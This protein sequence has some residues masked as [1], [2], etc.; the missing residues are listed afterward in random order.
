MI[1]RWL[2]WL[3]HSW[4]TC[5]DTGIAIHQECRVCGKRRG[6]V[7]M[8]YG[9]VWHTSW[10]LDEIPGCINMNWVNGVTNSLATSH[11]LRIPPQGGSGTAPPQQ[12]QE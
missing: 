4:R 11:A 9:L 5:S 12:L 8:P 6:G 10:W 3:F 7:R 1:M 2:H